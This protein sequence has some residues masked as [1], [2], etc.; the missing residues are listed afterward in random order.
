MGDLLNH[1]NGYE[2]V[3][4]FGSLDDAVSAVRSAL[5]MS[6]AVNA[7]LL[8]QHLPRLKDEYAL[9]PHER[10][11]LQLI[12]AGQRYKKIAASLGVS[13]NTVS[14]HVRSIYSK[15]DVHSKAEAVAKALKNHLV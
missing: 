4:S 11:I 1:A 3:G 13:L 6:T 9:T 2:R 12:V 7:V 15:L 10:R 8:I 14:F 5:E